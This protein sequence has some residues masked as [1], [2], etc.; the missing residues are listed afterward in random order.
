MYFNNFNDPDGM[1]SASLSS[2]SF[3]DQ[4]IDSFKPPLLGSDATTQ[5]SSS[6]SNSNTVASN[7][8]KIIGIVI[9]SFLSGIILFMIIVNIIQ[10][11]FRNELLDDLDYSTNNVSN[12]SSHS[13]NNR[14]SDDNASSNNNRD[15]QNDKLANPRAINRV[16]CELDLDECNETN[17]TSSKKRQENLILKESLTEEEDDDNE[18]SIEANERNLSK[19][20]VYTYQKKYYDDEDDDY[21]E[22]ENDLQSDSDE[23]RISSSREENK[24][25]S[26]FQQENDSLFEGD[27]DDRDS[28]QFNNN[29]NNYNNS[30]NDKI[31]NKKHV[32]FSKKKKTHD[33]LELKRTISQEPQKLIKTK[34]S[35]DSGR[36]FS[37]LD[38]ERTSTPPPMEII[39]PNKQNNSFIK[40]KIA[41]A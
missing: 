12:S 23:Y 34:L 32:K 16:S 30:K 27:D 3:F 41:Q 10:Y 29:N 19:V 1:F 26:R 38:S 35:Q 2:S 20:K 18:A 14:N 33:A 7:I 37:E 11:K 31:L 28:I 5:T 4:P 17:R 25:I 6:S 15:E 36:G 24:S 39:N 22:D 40:N 13:A 9:V 8:G 21:Y